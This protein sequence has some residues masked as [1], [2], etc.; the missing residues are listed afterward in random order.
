MALRMPQ[1]RPQRDYNYKTS[2]GNMPSDSPRCITVRYR[3]YSHKHLSLPNFTVQSPPLPT[4][5]VILI[6]PYTMHIAAVVQYHYCKQH[7]LF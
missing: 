7:T 4:H 5:N 6:H 1:K 2:Q 3:S